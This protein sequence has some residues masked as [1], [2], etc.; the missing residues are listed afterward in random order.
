MELY[1]RIRLTTDKYRDK[2]GQKGDTGYIIEIYLDKANTKH[3]EV[4]FSDP[5]TGIDYAQFVVDEG[6]IELAE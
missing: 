5:Q 6:D 1:N 2:N 3:Y 4:E